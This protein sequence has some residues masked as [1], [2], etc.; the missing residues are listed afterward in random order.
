MNCASLPVPEL[1]EKSQDFLFTVLASKREPLEIEPDAVRA[2]LHAALMVVLRRATPCGGLCPRMLTGGPIAPCSAPAEL[3]SLCRSRCCSSHAPGVP[4][5]LKGTE[6]SALL[7]Q[8]LLLQKCSLVP[9]WGTR[10]AEETLG[11]AGPVPPR[12]RHTRASAS[13]SASAHSAV[14]GPACGPGGCCARAR[15]ALLRSVSSVQSRHLL[16]GNTGTEPVFQNHTWNSFLPP[17]RLPLAKLSHVNPKSSPAAAQHRSQQRSSAP[18]P[19]VNRLFDPPY[20]SSGVLGLVR[21]P[22][23]D[24]RELHSSALKCRTIS[25][26]LCNQSSGGRR[27]G[28][29]ACSH[30]GQSCS[31]CSDLF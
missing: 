1:P 5:S 21:M 14:L 15:G 2:S 28:S 24:T 7:R 26:P 20:P 27:R 6:L 23:P 9:S 18:G 16:G 29:S 4:G 22:P 30:T 12:P 17:K 13:S 31:G 19:A 3:P 8:E 10:V 25:D 11:S